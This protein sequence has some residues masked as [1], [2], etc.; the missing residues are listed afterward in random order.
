MPETRGMWKQWAFS[1]KD[2]A[3]QK[4]FRPVAWVTISLM[5]ARTLLGLFTNYHLV[6][7]DDTMSPIVG[8]PQP[9]VWFALAM[10]AAYF[11]GAIL[12]TWPRFE[13]FLNGYPEGRTAERVMVA[14]AILTCTIPAIAFTLQVVEVLNG[15]LDSS[16]PQT[17]TVRT[18]KKV[19]LAS[20][21]D[22]H[23]ARD[24]RNPR[25]WVYFQADNRFTR[26][27]PLGSAFPFTTK[28]GRFGYEWYVSR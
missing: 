25:E 11:L 4:I 2:L 6:L 8:S 28:S 3:R 20:S 18:T 19:I 15:M 26:Q 16:P 12:L 23:L 17:R 24:W 13:R 27:H 1:E 5:V 7:R 21:T 9:F 22:Y 10:G 14:V